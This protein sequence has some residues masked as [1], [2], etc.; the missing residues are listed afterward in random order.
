MAQLCAVISDLPDNTL[1]LQI[2]APHLYQFCP[3]FF[4]Q[5]AE[6]AEGKAVCNLSQKFQFLQCVHGIDLLLL[7]TKTMLKD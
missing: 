3:C 5:T 7:S 1:L 6:A 4:C 2:K